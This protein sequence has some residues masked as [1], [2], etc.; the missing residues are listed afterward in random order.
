MSQPQALPFDLS[1]RP[2][3]RLVHDGPRVGPQSTLRDCWEVYVLPELDE[4]TAATL[5]EYHD[6]LALWERYTGNPPVEAINRETVKGFRQA[7]MDKPFVRGRKRRKRSPE[8]VNKHLR[9]LAAALSPLWP[10]DRHNP[11][12]KGF[13]PFFKFPTRL[14]RQKTL[15]FVFSLA[16]MTALYRAADACLVPG[17]HRRGGLYV[18]ALWRLAFVLAFNTGP[19]TWDLFALR[20]ED[21]RWDDFRYGSVYYAARKT[22]K[23]QRPPL[24]RCSRTHL[25]YVQSLGLDADLVF[26][27]FTKN[28]AF[29]RAWKRI[30]ATAGLQ[31]DFEDFRKTC[32]T[33]HD[34]VVPGVGAWLTGHEVHGVN[35]QNYQN[36]TRRVCNAVYRRKLPK[37]FVEGARALR[38]SAAAQ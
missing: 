18:P 23:F 15:P 37:G 22:V 24:N 20:W 30:C 28:D 27:G 6:T 7:L 12:G 13:L 31:A 5:R 33:L 21:V 19:R 36:P 10:A 38:E 4:R 29:Y 3:L 16:Q 35:A 1:A 2:T 8:T 34:D 26:P 9:N 32:S 11:G 17:Q 14:P 25:E